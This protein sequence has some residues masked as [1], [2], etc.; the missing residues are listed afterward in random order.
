LR[1]VTPSS[2]RLSP[3]EDQQEHNKLPKIRILLLPLG[4]TVVNSVLV[5]VGICDIRQRQKNCLSTKPFHIRSK[6]D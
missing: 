6:L 1:L 2:V 3:I 4:F 5:G